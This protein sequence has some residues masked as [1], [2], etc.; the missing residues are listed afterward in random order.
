MNRPLFLALISIVLWASLA[1]LSQG[2]IHLP[3]FLLTAIAF[4]FGSLLSL[5]Q[6]KKWPKA[7]QTLAL[8]TFGIFGYH[9]L[10]FTA[11][12]HAP[13]LEANLINYLWP[14]LIVFLS[15]V[16]LPG[17]PLGFRHLLAALMALVGAVLSIT[18]GKAHFESGYLYGYLLAFAAAFTWAAYSVLAKRKSSEE[19]S[20]VGGACLLSALL[21]LICH[22]VLEPS[23]KIQ[24]SDWGRLAVLGL[25]PMG[26][27]FYT[28]EAAIRKGDPRAIGTLS[29]F[30]PLLSTAILAATSGGNILTLTNGAAL[31][32]ILSAAIIGKN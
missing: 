7:P 32:L 24:S 25:G 6:F 21:S 23:V 14:M 1:A 20:V 4:A 2:L 28:W 27:A 12:R 5:H 9:F 8:T 17:H 13:I 15:S 10:L 31:A 26:T 22:V 18:G 16:L 30:T 19:A 29:Y 11:F 3:P